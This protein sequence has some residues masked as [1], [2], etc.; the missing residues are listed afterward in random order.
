MCV[1]VPNN[2][3]K[4]GH[5]LQMCNCHH[6]TYDQHFSVHAPVNC[7]WGE[8]GEWAACSAHCGGGQRQRAR[9]KAFGVTVQKSSTGQSYFYAL[10]KLNRPHGGGKDCQG[11]PEQEEVCN[12]QVCTETEEIEPTAKRAAAFNAFAPTTTTLRIQTK[13]NSGQRLRGDVQE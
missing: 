9:A 12:A 1:D 2:N 5:M 3:P 13:E 6:R 7:E 10:K 11:E 4:N 8:W